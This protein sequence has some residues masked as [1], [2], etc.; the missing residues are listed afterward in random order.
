MKQ[1]PAV[2]AIC[3][4]VLVAVG[5][6]AAP[7]R[8]IAQNDAAGELSAYEQLMV[9]IV[10]RT[11]AD[12]D[13]EAARM[14]IDLNEGLAEGTLGSEAREPLAVNL[15]LSEAAQLHTKDLFANFD[16]LPSDHRGSDGRDPTQRG[17]DAGAVFVGGVAE[18]N[19]WSSSGGG[20]LSV[21]AVGTLH[22]LLFRDFTPNFEVVGRGHR[23]V[24]LNGTRNEIGVGMGSGAFGSRTAAIVTYD[25]TTSN[26]LYITGV[27]IADSVKSN[28]FYDVGEGLGGVTIVATPV[29]GGAAF[30]TTTQKAG[31][32][33][34]AVPPGAYDLSATGGGL[35]APVAIEGIVVTDRNVKADVIVPK[36]YAPPPAAGFSVAK[37]LAKLGKDG[38][39]SCV[40]KRAGLSFGTLGLSGADADA[41]RVEIEGVTYFTLGDRALGLDKRQVDAELGLV[42]KL[43]LKDATKNKLK[44]DLKKGTLT[45]TVKSVP[46]FDPTTGDVDIVVRTVADVASLTAPTTAKNAKKHVFGPVDGTVGGL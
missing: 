8:A 26:T 11:R 34:L 39:W 15:C 45:I 4:L 12:P 36:A 22:T 46:G 7:G 14:G 24:M 21:G 2:L 16:D 42:R 30:S 35:G 19:A 13:A 1:R 44:L 6:G 20:K 18:N 23:K 40:V 33:S 41:F 25:L 3:G 28:H 32:Y 5:Q 9:E 31:G 10:N 38:T 17:T 37:G 27:A 29:G 43:V